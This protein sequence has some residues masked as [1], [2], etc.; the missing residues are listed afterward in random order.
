MDGN[1]AWALEVDLLS[2]GT[3]PMPPR[4][5]QHSNVLVDIYTFVDAVGDGGVGRASYSLVHQGIPGVFH[6]LS[7]SENQRYGSLVGETVYELFI[8]A[9]QENGTSLLLRGAGAGWQFGIDGIRYG[10]VSEGVK[11][12][13]GSQR[14]VLARVGDA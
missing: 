1:P 11:Q 4:I 7:S 3:P 10:A 9:R 6:P 13:D 12:A 14:V 8:P 5:G 2:F